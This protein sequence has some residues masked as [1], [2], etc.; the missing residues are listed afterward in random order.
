MHGFVDQGEIALGVDD[1]HG[2][3]RLQ[4]LDVVAD[5]VMGEVVLRAE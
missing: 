5:H 4:G 2:L 1:D 3:K